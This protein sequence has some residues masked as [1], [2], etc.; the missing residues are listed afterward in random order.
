MSHSCFP[1]I[2]NL[3][4]KAVLK[5]IT[6]ID[7]AKEDA[8]DYVPN[9]IK[10]DPIATIRASSIR[11]QYFSAILKALEKKDLQL[12][13]DIDIRW[14]STLLMVERAITLQ[15]AIRKFLSSNEF[16]E[17]RK[18]N[19]SDS[20]WDALEVFQK[21]LVV[22]HAFQQRLSAEKT[23]TLSYAIPSFKAMS[24]AWEKQAEDCA[25]LSS[26]IEP[27]LNKLAVYTARTDSVPAYI[28]AMAINPAI[29]LDWFSH[30][31]PEKVQL[32]KDLFINEVC[33]IVDLLL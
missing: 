2:V 15:E 24:S 31:A 33:L 21:I 20:E 3:A 32:M 22:P 12:L 13:R 11:R 27:G 25:D 28:L 4:C 7:F 19:L 26:I 8:E 23:P 6:N 30:H 5:A 18:Y 17:L 1:H 16:P 10:R 9:A 29:K 14:S